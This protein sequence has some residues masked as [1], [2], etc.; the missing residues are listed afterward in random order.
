MI[1]SL[2][3]IALVV[4]DY[5]EA[6]EFYVNKLNFSLVEDTVLSAT[7]RWVVI[8]PKGTN[9]CKILLA[10]A[11]NQQQELSIGNQTGGRVF[12]FLHTIDIENDFVFLKNNNVKIVR[13]ISDEPY[14]KV[15]VFE[16]LY[17]NLWDVIEPKK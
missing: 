15:F 1:N 3:Q 2:V 9:S 11:T 16:D 7:K 5:D 10:K 12:L 17:G 6:I 14:G 8:T 13:P 4:K